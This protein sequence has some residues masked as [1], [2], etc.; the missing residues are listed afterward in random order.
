[1]RHAAFLLTSFSLALVLFSGVKAQDGKDKK[2]A[3]E[4]TLKGKI[5]CAKCDLGTESECNTVIVVKQ[6]DKE[7]IYYFDPAGH[8]KHHDAICADPKNGSVTGIV[9]DDG[10]RKIIEVKSAK[11]D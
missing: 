11:F 5:T 4:V 2:G 8:K 7:T 6:N 3:K 10:K 1:M 9:R